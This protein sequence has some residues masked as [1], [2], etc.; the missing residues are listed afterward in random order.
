MQVVMMTGMGEQVWYNGWVKRVCSVVGITTGIT[1]DS[2][3]MLVVP[4]TSMMI[5]CESRTRR[6]GRD[7]IRCGSV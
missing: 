5:W 4:Y 1:G 6:Q 3:M 7:M 2:M